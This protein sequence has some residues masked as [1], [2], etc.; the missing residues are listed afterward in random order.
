[1]SN[2]NGIK[3]EKRYDRQLRIWGVH[4][5]RRLEASRVC[6]LNAGMHNSSW[7]IAVWDIICKLYG[8]T[9]P[10]ST[11]SFIYTRVRKPMNR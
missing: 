9:R 8:P 4:G 7:I 10:E 2:N 1:M 6:V 3:N 11:Y 5:Q